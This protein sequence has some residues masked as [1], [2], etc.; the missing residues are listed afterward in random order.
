VIPQ[1]ISDLLTPVALAHLILGDGSLRPHGLIICTDSY[2]VQ[3]V[4]IFMNVLVI[5]YRLECTLR[6]PTPTSPRIYIKELSMPV[7]I[8][9]VSLYFPP[10]MY[11]KLRIG[12]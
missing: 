8:K 1:N 10:S 7:L 4:I 5:K 12:N 11:Y 6:F 3:Q 2:S 9:I